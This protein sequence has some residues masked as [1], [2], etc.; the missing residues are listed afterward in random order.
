MEKREIRGQRSDEEKAGSKIARRREPHGKG[1]TGSTRFPYG[2]F[3]VLT[4]IK[5][6]K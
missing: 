5:T 6:S 1:R 2:N 3:H 4:I